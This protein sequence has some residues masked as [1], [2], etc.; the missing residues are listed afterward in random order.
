MAGMVY[1]DPFSEESMRR[2]LLMLLLSVFPVFAQSKHPF[3]FEDMMS[4]KRVGEPIVSPDGKWVLFSAIDVDLASNKKTPHIWIVP[5][6]G[7]EARVAIAGQAG[8]RPRWSPVGNQFLF[9]SN[10][11]GG[12]QIW[13]ADFDG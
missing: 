2:C 12:S 13:I 6:A 3:K 7:G 9:L 1:T 10:K 4:L 11:E 5:T 8:D